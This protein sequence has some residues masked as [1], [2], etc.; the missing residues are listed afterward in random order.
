MK[1]NSQSIPPVLL[2]VDQYCVA[3]SIGRTQFYKFVSA[4]LISTVKIG[5]KGVRV[6]ASELAALPGRLL[7][8]EQ[9]AA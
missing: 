1:H 8:R 4:G 6:P 7:D 3:A 9:A 5:R 2:T